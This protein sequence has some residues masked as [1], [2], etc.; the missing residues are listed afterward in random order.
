MTYKRLTP[1]QRHVLILT[2][3]GLHTGI[4]AKDLGITD[5]A[6]NKHRSITM[7]KLG[8]Q[9]VAE[10]TRYAVKHRLVEV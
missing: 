10:L 1:R 4:I 5:D 3:N 8:I 9:S 2:A 6:V 7:R